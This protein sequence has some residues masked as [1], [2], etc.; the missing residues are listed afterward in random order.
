MKKLLT[1]SLLLISAT[2][3]FGAVNHFKNIGIIAKSFIHSPRGFLKALAHV[4]RNQDAFMGQPLKMHLERELTLIEINSL[5][6]ETGISRAT[7]AE[8]Y[9]PVPS[10][11]PG[12]DLVNPV[13]NLQ[14][15]FTKEQNL[16]ILCSRLSSL[17]EIPGA[18]TIL[19]KHSPLLVTGLLA[20][21]PGTDEYK[22][23]QVFPFTK[24]LV[25]KYGS[26]KVKSLL[27]SVEK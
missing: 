8:K 11:L 6:K 7:I 13:L 27:Y 14:R 23:E 16:A 18:E 3:T 9:K 4:Y 10:L 20:Q 21:I 5:E 2:S 12:G 22:A 26:Q 17:P 25:E 15:P 19:H 1:L 24:N